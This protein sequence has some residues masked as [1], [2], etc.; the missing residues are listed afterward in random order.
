MPVVA[1]CAIHVAVVQGVLLPFQQV[2]AAGHNVAVC[3]PPVVR[4]SSALL[5]RHVV[6]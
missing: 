3:L 5:A 6:G 2:S 1:L 4:Y